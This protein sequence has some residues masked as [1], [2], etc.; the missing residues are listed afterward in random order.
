MDTHT[1]TVALCAVKHI[2]SS[3]NIVKLDYDI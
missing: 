2:L 3:T 1:Q